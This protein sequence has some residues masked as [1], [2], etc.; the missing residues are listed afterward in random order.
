MLAHLASIALRATSAI[1]PII[2]SRL[3]AVQAAIWALITSP[4][5]L[6]FAMWF[7]VDVA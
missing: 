1:G 2:C 7:D 4:P 6:H 3:P 5:D